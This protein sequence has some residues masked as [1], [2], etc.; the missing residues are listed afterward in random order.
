MFRLFRLSV[1]LLIAFVTGIFF[2]RSH[3][4]ELCENSGGQWMRAGFC[5]EKR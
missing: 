1:L 5:A 3:Q 4:K 2:E